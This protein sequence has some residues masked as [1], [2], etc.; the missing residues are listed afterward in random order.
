MQRSG[1]TG[2]VLFQ[3][4]DDLT[5]ASWSFRSPLFFQH[6]R[7]VDAQAIDGYKPIHSV[8]LIGWSLARVL[9]I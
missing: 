2:S 6:D 3:Q 7:I 5:G 1:L 8:T 9:L 4:H